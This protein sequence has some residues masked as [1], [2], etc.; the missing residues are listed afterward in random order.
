M[1]TQGHLQIQ[2]ALDRLVRGLDPERVILYGSRATKEA[3][4]GSDVDLLLLADSG[5]DTSIFLHR[6]RQLTARVFPPIDL[7]VTTPEQVDDAYAGKS[8]FLLSILECGVT[9]YRRPNRVV[10]YGHAAGGSL[11]SP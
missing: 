6:A 3:R 5:T 9:V 1:S 4:P 8:P 7:A 11:G 2:A 10:N